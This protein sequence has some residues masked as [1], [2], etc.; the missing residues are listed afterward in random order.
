VSSISY[1]TLL[2]SLFIISLGVWVFGNWGALDRE[3][4]TRMIGSLIALVLVVA[5]SWLVLSDV[6]KARNQRTVQLAPRTGSQV[7]GQDWEPFSQPRLDRYVQN[8]I[9]VFVAVGAKW[10]LT[11]Q[12]NHLVLETEKVK[13]AFIKYGVVKMYAD[14]TLNDEEVTR[15]LRSLGRNGVPV[16]AVYSHD[17]N[18]RPEVMPEL[19]TQ[20]MVINAL[21][22]AKK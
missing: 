17:P 19:I 6:Y 13:Q 16:Y 5:G 1:L 9:P 21:K 3:R 15:Y 20:D 11:C 7:V 2:V 12:T 14:W 10:C 22:E 8:G 18:K 4:R